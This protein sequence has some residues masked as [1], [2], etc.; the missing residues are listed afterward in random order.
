MC[1]HPPFAFI[2]VALASSLFAQPAEAVSRDRVFVASY[3]NDAN[4]CTFLSPCKTF[5]QAVNVVAAGGEVTAI[6][7]AGFGPITIIQA[8]TITSPAGVEAGVVPVAGGDAITINAGASDAVVLRGL[9]LNGSGV[10]Y[11]GV[12]FNSGRSLTVTDSVVQNFVG[13]NAAGTIGNGILIQPSSGTVDLAITNTTASNNVNFGILYQPP[14][15]SPTANAVIDHV[16]AAGNGTGIGVITT[17]AAGGAVFTAISNSIASN[18]ANGI[19]AENPQGTITLS[20]DNTG[21]TSNGEGVTAFGTPKVLLGRS[22]I[23]GNLTGITND[24]SP[25]TFYTYG[26]NQ[27]D[28][29]TTDISSALNTTFT[30]R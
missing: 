30:P 3:G 2:V 25:N 26:N 22:V 11:N 23:T 6:D 28:L 13:S 18:N 19:F 29:N 5:Q 20:I 9:T 17:V 24:T 21:V 7:S 27:I 12:V 16:V 1:P 4:P 15:G 10:G 8:V 14:S